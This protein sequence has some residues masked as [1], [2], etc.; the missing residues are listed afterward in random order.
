MRGKGLAHFSKSA[1]RDSRE[2]SDQKIRDKSMLDPSANT[3]APP[4]FAV[5]DDQ[6]AVRDMAGAFAAEVFAPK[7]VAW[8]AGCMYPPT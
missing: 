1:P 7:A 6:I 4:Q 5:G 2:N 8:G 3:P